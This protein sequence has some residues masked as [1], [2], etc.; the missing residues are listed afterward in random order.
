[1]Q[2]AHLIGICGKAMAGLAVILKEQ[3][4]EISGSD[5]GFYDPVYSYLKDRDITFAP[6]H[7]KENIPP[8]ASFIVIGKHAKLVPESNEEVAAAFARGIIPIRSL[9]EVL[10]ELMQETDNIVI[11]GSFGKSS[12][13][14]IITWC[15]L[16]AKQ[17]PSYLIGAVPFGFASAAHMGKDKTFV[18]EGDEYPS[19]NWDTTSKFLYYRPQTVLLTSGE[20]D[21]LNVFPTLAQYLSPFQKLAAL[22]PA[23]GLLVA[24]K[25]GAH[26]MDDIVPHAK[27]RVVTYGMNT[28]ADW[29]PRDIRYG[30]ETTFTLCNKHGAVAELATTGLGEYN[31][32][33]IVGC[34]AVLL[35]K[36]L[37]TPAQLVEGIRTFQGVSGRLD[38]KHARSTVAIYEGYGSSHAKM[39]SLFDALKLHFPGK[40]IIA[41]FEPH[42]FSWRNRAALSWYDHAFDAADTVLIFEPPTHGA[43]TQDQ[44][45]LGE[46]V[47]K[48][49]ERHENVFP[50]HTKEEGLTLL[51]NVLHEDDLVL[52]ITSGDLGGIIP[53]VPKLAEEKFPLPLLPELTYIDEHGILGSNF[54]WHKHDAK[55]ISL[56]EIMAIGLTDGRVQVSKKIIE[57]LKKVDSILKARGF[58][59]YIKEG[60]RSKELYEL[61]FKKRSEK[62]GVEETKRLFNMEGM[63]HAKGMSVDVALWDLNE[64]REVFMRNGADGTDALFVDYYKNRNDEKSKEYQDLQEFV[65]TTMLAQGFSL[66]TK[67]E[68]FH[69][70]YK[71]K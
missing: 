12:C 31:I 13:T 51:G 48:V 54:Y 9:P 37:V 69:F 14:S 20:H 60:Y 18:I 35:E 34:A 15:L 21:H 65:I 17:D 50:F 49:A 64:D 23:D 68:Y 27:A 52:L 30:S 33:N 42:T 43:G 67:N 8:D 7:A 4:F 44:L 63:P 70:D 10:H 32:E 46:I 47:S 56:E 22:L 55:G 29:Y 16:A 36:E 61:V 66:G 41:V 62:F 57:P 28:A 58:R 24:S 59:L 53:E 19:A 25:S 6:K 40:R 39:Q 5:E 71:E 38:R 11:A 45:S 26:V 2:K 1:M 3:G